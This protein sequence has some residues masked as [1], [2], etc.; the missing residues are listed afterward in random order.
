MA[1]SPV[2]EKMFELPAEVDLHLDGK[3]VTVKG[4]LGELKRDFSTLPITIELEDKQ[5]TVKSFWPRKK[6]RALIGTAI[7]HIKNMVKGTTEG[8]TYKLKV[9]SSHFPVTVKTQPGKLVIE[10]FLGE[11]RPRI[12]RTKGDVKITVKGDEITVQGTNIEEVSQTAATIEK[13]TKIKGKDSRVFLDGI[14]IQQ[15]S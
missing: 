12:I 1:R 15:K 8:Y 3:I 14:F 5:I 10:N 4:P 11:K 13:A 2:E 7:A 6:E 9:V